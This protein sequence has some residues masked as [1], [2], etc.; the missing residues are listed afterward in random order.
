MENGT[1]WQHMAHAGGSVNAGSI[2]L[3]SAEKSSMQ[4]AGLPSDIK[5][6]CYALSFHIAYVFSPGTELKAPVAL[7]VHGRLLFF[8]FFIFVFF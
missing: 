3:Q 2:E 6:C 4:G 1:Q 5:W 8:Y 7:G